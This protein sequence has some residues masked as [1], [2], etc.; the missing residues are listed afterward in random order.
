[1]TDQSSDVAELLP[2]PFCGYDKPVPP[3]RGEGRKARLID[4]LTAARAE[5]QNA[6]DILND[7]EFL[8]WRDCARD[9][10]ANLTLA[11]ARIESMEYG[12]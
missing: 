9:V 12:E 10:I 1:M 4:E 7:A 11:S 3:V 8:T 5:Y 2:C 6:I